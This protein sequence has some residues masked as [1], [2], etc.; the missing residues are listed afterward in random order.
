MR[1]SC[2][3]QDSNHSPLVQMHDRRPEFSVETRVCDMV[4]QTLRLKR[5]LIHHPEPQTI[6]EN[7]LIG[8]SND[9][10]VFNLCRFLYG[11]PRSAQWGFLGKVPT[12]DD[13]FVMTAGDERTPGIG[14]WRVAK[15][16]DDGFRP[17]HRITG[18]GEDKRHVLSTGD[19]KSDMS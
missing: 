19:T 5:Q 8:H 13:F 16:S 4:T 9:L 7:P 18:G 1:G 11:V 10:K 12:G 6:R 2:Y 15:K 14:H 17:K 3:T